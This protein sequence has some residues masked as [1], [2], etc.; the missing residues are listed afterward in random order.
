MNVHTVFKRM[1]NSEVREEPVVEEDRCR[2]TKCNVVFPSRN[3]LFKH[4]TNCSDPKVAQ[5]KLLE[6][7]ERKKRA[8][9]M[10]LSKQR[11]HIREI[12]DIYQTILNH[13]HCSNDLQELQEYLELFLKDRENAMTCISIKY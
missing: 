7:N 2:C 4:I 10:E 9:E 13:S 8:I 6:E 11:E 3:K 5:Q 12:E 1:I